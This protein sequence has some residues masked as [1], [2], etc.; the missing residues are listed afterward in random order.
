M[1]V[2]DRVD[3][4]RWSMSGTADSARA[5]AFFTLDVF[6]LRLT[7]LDLAGGF[8]R[9]LDDRGVY[10]G[11][12]LRPTEPSEHSRAGGDKSAQD[13]HSLFLIH[14]ISEGV[15]PDCAMG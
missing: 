9:G 8:G 14:A 5:R 2:D 7:G 12:G 10:L 6:G 1:T 11:G 4:A 3:F 15:P 13:H